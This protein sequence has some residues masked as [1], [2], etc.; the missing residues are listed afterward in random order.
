MPEGQL[1]LGDTHVHSTRSDGHLSPAELNLVAAAKGLDFL[2]LADHAKGRVG[3]PPPSQ[4]GEARGVVVLHGQEVSAGNH[5]HFVVLGPVAPLH[6]IPLARVPE[7]ADAAHAAA[8]VIILAHPWTVF[9]RTPERVRQ[10]D[11]LFA[12]GWLDGLEVISGAL[13]PTI[14]GDWRR[15][16]VHYLREWAPFGPA[17]LASSDWH[18]RSHGRTLALGAS[19]LLAKTLSGPDLLEGIARRQTAAVLPRAPGLEDGMYQEY[20]QLIDEVAP[21][22]PATGPHWRGD[23]FGPPEM[24]DRIESAQRTVGRQ[25]GELLNQPGNSR[26][27]EVRRAALAAG[28]A[29]NYRRALALL[30]DETR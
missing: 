21:L 14:F 26:Q 12:E 8:G 24:L 11:R 13:K 9:A 3:T 17:T 1:F 23:L 27:Q 28:A 10:V 5:L 7:V 18:H 15:M 20:R 16:F 22:L 6:E 19:Y 4:T 29:G 30:S 25:L 2:A